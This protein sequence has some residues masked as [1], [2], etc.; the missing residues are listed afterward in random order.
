MQGRNPMAKN[1]TDILIRAGLDLDNL[2][3]DLTKADKKI[4]AAF[5]QF[6]SSRIELSKIAKMSQTAVT[7]IDELSGH[8]KYF[9]KKTSAATKDA[10]DELVKLKD[11]LQE[12]AQEAANYQAVAAQSIDPG[13]RERFEA[14]SSKAIAKFHEISQS[15]EKTKQATKANYQELQN[16]SKSAGKFDK[17]LKDF[18]KY[19]NMFDDVGKAAALAF[20]NP[21]QGLLAAAKALGSG[22]R[23][24]VSGI[25]SKG[26]AAGPD[27]SGLQK[28]MMVMAKAAGSIAGISS[29]FMLV[30]KIVDSITGKTKE[31]NKALMDGIPLSGDWAAVAAGGAATYVSALKSMRT[32]AVENEYEFK[33]LGTDATGALKVVSAFAKE[34]SGSL[35]R[36]AADLESMGGTIEGGFKKFTE[37]AILYGKA[38]G[39]QGEETATMMGSWTSELGIGSNRVLEIIGTVASEARSS[40][41]PVHKF[42]D[43]FKSVTPNLDL[44]ANRIENLTAM[45]KSLS[46]NMSPASVKQFM[47][48]FSKGFKGMD[49]TSRL[50][51]VLLAGPKVVSGALKKSFAR[52]SVDAA[53]DFEK[54]GIKP[55]EFQA[56][57][58]KGGKDLQVVLARAKAMGATGAEIEKVQRTARYEKY[59]SAGEGG[60]VTMLASAM[61]EG[62]MGAAYTITKAMSQSLGTGF[63]GIMEHVQS[64]IGISDEQRAALEKMDIMLDGVKTEL[65]EAG[66]TTNKT[67]NDQLLLQA[68]SKDKTLA[69]GKMSTAE[70]IAKLREIRESG[71]IQGEKLKTTMTSLSDD[72]IVEAMQRNTESGEKVD[73][74]KELNYEQYQATTSLGDKLEDIFSVL[75]NKIFVVLEPVVGWLNDIFAY[76][77][78]NKD[79]QNQIKAVKEL[80]QA[81]QRDY[82]GDVGKPMREQSSVVSNTLV[83][84]IRKG[85]TGKDLTKS[86]AQTGIFEG[87]NAGKMKKAFYSLMEQSGSRGGGRQERAFGAAVKTGNMEEIL[88][89]ITELPGDLATNLMYFQ[90]KLGPTK[91]AMELAQ[92]GPARAGT[93]TPKDM[94]AY[95]ELKQINAELLAGMSDAETGMTT[96]ADK[97][98]VMLAERKRMIGLQAKRG[99]LLSGGDPKKA[100]EAAVASV[101]TVE[102]ADAQ[103]KALEEQNQKLEESNKVAKKDERALS[104]VADAVDTGVV[105]K[106][107]DTKKIM[108]DSTLEAFRT[109][110]LEFSVILAKILTDPANF[111]TSLAGKGQTLL[112]A[113][114]TTSDVMSLGANATDVDALIKQIDDRNKAAPSKQLGGMIPSTGLY[115]M[116][117]GER[118]LPASQAGG[119]GGGMTTNNNTFIIK[120]NNPVTVA[121]AVKRVL[122]EAARRH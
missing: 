83:E 70:Y 33:K 12:A 22:A 2:E 106:P 53:R 6:S 7:E 73:A 18:A 35:V 15:I 25:A 34:S 76:M 110:L 59:R 71:T 97:S 87:A 44:F 113:G 45:I 91:A 43:I 118:V 79:Q 14:A 92:G 39:M 103:L 5:K 23:A 74:L 31:L 96:V 94:S 11:N 50:K 69:Q 49:F 101:D 17:Q 111:G 30:F 81:F 13:Q 115:N 80:N 77:S 107:N 117:K 98:K 61:K 36:T 41:I 58:S 28:T 114:A 55:E 122:S 120:S 72:E 29:A 26:M 116:H 19:D 86:V 102:A 24:G 99:A 46:K 27:A 63:A 109:A 1:E 67:L 9:G 104:N 90:Q 78:G 112:G 89:V 54:Y 85:L 119:G 47:D 121:N 93:V 38:L 88:S 20:K 56:A 75:T 16:L 32:A 105:L 3:K 100:E 65:S 48:A 82:K 66:A 57:W 42:M 84:G 64:M 62:D 60:D 40:N 95:T 10:V 4:K 8:M 51:T 108:K 52:V 68:A 37:N 21:A